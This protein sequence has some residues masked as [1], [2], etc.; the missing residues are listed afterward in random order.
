MDSSELSPLFVASAQTVPYCNLY[1]YVWVEKMQQRLE[2]VMATRF[3]F[4]LKLQKILSLHSK[5][6][7][8]MYL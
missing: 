5:N 7:S 1:R 8:F 4:V 2:W 3:L 6:L